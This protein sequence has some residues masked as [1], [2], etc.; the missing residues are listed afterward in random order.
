MLY[1][2][3]SRIKGNFQLE[4]KISNFTVAS[5]FGNIILETFSQKMTQLLKSNLPK[6]NFEFVKNSIMKYFR[7]KTTTYNLI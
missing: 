3:G 7:T 1:E 2:Y 6:N 5:S 4:P